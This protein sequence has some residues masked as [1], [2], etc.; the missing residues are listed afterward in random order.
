MFLNFDKIYDHWTE[1]PHWLRLLIFY[2]LILLTIK[3]NCN[4]ISWIWICEKVGVGKIGSTFYVQLNC[5]WY[6]EEQ[7]CK[8]ALKLKRWRWW[9]WRQ[10]QYSRVCLCSAWRQKWVVVHLRLAMPPLLRCSPF[11]C[12]RLKW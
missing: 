4:R 6:K 9:W 3:W 10:W 1:D 7:W 11:S 8:R 2:A 12:F 5:Q